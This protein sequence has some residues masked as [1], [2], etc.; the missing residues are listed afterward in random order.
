M[1]Q[2]LLTKVL[3]LF[4]LIVGSSS[5]AWAADDPEL[6][7][8]FTSAWTAG[9][10][11]SAGEKVFTKKI[12]DVTYTISGQGGT[13]FK[14]SSG[15]FIFGKKDAY[16]NL[17]KVNF[18]VE[19]I[20]V[21]GNASGSASTKMNIFVGTTA[22]STE[23]TGCSSDGTASTLTYQ[24]AEGY[25]TA[26][27]QYVLK[28]TS[29]HNA[30]I[31]KVHYYKKTGGSTNVVSI[32]L[33]NPGT[34]TYTSAQSV[35]ISSNTTDASIYYTMTIDGTT[36][37]E[38]TVN[39]TPY[40]SAIS[41]TKNGTQI[42]ARAFKTGMDP[43]SI[44]TA[45][46]TIKPTTPTISAAGATVSISGDE[47]CTFYYTTNGNTPT[48]ES[49]E[50]STPFT[51]DADCTIKA[52]AYD[53]NGNAS[54]VKSFTFKYM[55][56]APKDINSN[57]YVKVTDVST[58]EN[59]DAI[60][61]V[62][63]D[64]EVALSTTQNS[65]NRG[66]ADVIISDNTIFPAPSDAQKLV[67]VKLTEAIDNVDKDVFYF[68]TGSGYLYAAS[69]SSNHLKTEATPDNNN[70]ARAT[71]SIDNGDATIKFTGTNARNWLKHNPGPTNGNLFSCYNPADEQM[72]IVQIY[73]E[74]TAIPAT[75]TIS[76]SGW[77][78][79]SS[80]FPLD[81]STIEGGMAY[82]AS[83]VTDGKVVLT[84][85]T[86]KVPAGTGLMIKGTPDDDFSIDVTADETT[87]PT[88]LLE[89]LPNGGK[90]EV[91]DEGF[92]YV[93]GWTTPENPGFYKIVSDEPTLGAG[94]AYLHTST[95]LNVAQAP[96]LGLDVDG[97]TTSIVNINRET[98]NDN[99]YYTLDG[100]RVAQ[101][102][103][104]LYIVNGRKVIV[105]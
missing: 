37:A 80:N 55:P 33:F 82:V 83:D 56:L 7:L 34:G 14:F 53:A 70:N 105:K 88:N 86:G 58:L 24:I 77:N 93:F 36:P 32:P 28:V 75:G 64:D 69:G 4:A 59:G 102:T 47:G 66:E 20:V 22:V 65:N 54:D 62:C 76:A 68:Y 61:I 38:P 30:Q 10:D 74:V 9:Q 16:I 26:N 100:R 41:V 17:P 15:Y 48:N 6:T 84:A 25:E 40:T 52:I 81:L 72:D 73:K 2:F 42:K 79:F 99:Q 35:E 29:S 101:P 8:D 3:L 44:A 11:N 78:T 104:G 39:S 95:A 49:T 23:T 103:K 18:D 43:S 96:F 90:V 51:L 85:A 97:E 13:N 92:N 91:A 27:T 50:Y 87:A 19:K 1:K 57:Y 98:I 67:L 71:I 21:I 46:Y 89:G 60:L 31:T 45:T 94:K 63:E 12:G 5:V